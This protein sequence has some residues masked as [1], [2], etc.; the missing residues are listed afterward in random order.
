MSGF[1]GTNGRWSLEWIPNFRGLRVNDEN[2]RS[3]AVCHNI[4]SRL[5]REIIS[6][7]KLISKAPQMLGKLQDVRQFLRVHPENEPNSEMR[8]LLDSVDILIKEST[9]L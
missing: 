8:N 3:V 7:A 6:N 5:Q 2:G 9:E 4:K 1:K